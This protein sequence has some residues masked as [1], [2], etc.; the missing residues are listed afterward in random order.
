MKF[1]MIYMPIDHME[2]LYRSKNPFIR[3]PHIARLNA[4]VNEVKKMYPSGLKIFDAGCGEGQLLEMLQKEIPKNQYYG[5]D[6]TEVALIAAKKRC[7]NVS[8]RCVDLCNIDVPDGFFDIIICSEV[9]E[10]ISEW[11]KVTQE[12]C[13]ILSPNGHLII[14]FPNEIL[15]TLGRFFLRRRPIK[16][17]DHVNSF[18]PS[19]LK[20]NILL[21]IIR[22]KYFPVHIFSLSLWGMIHF[23]KHEEKN[24]Q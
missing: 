2:E 4:L 10:H 9:L 7:P 11:R 6:A 12:F 21:Q 13:R 17:P 8:F 23:Q 3:I 24:K 14:T 5:M 16:V 18:T 1:P 19:M 22:E 15:W 20:K